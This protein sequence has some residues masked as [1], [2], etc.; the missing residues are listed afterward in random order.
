M[1]QSI[2]NQGPELP[3]PERLPKLPD[4]GELSAP[5]PEITD[6]PAQQELL[7]QASHAVAQAA[8]DA[9]LVTPPIAAIQDQP[10]AAGPASV[11]GSPATAANGDVIEKEWIE[12]AKQIV[13][14]TKDDPRIQS[15]EMAR[16]KHDYIVKRYGKQ[17]KLPEDR[18]ANG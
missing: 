1:D 2:P 6:R 11:S 9:A 18:L 3:R 10:A 12:K 5:R 17:I 8:D 14:K 16:F 15:D 13:D 7:A 4:K